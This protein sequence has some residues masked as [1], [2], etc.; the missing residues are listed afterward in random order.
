MKQQFSTSSPLLSS[1]SSFS[2]FLLTGAFCFFSSHGWNAMSLVQCP[3]LWHL[4]HFPSLRCFLTSVSESRLT[5]SWSTS[6]AP[7]LWGVKWQSPNFFFFLK[8]WVLLSL[9]CLQPLECIVKVDAGI[10]DCFEVVQGF[11]SMVEVVAKVF[12]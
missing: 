11:S 4:K 2:V 8:E 1:S 5:S 6:I 12:V 10:D 9:N 7:S 3:T